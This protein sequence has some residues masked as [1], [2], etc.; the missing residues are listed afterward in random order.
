MSTDWGL[1]AQAHMA[2]QVTDA[3]QIQAALSVL[4]DKTIDPD[5]LTGS[6][7][8]FREAAIPYLSKG[9]YTAQT[10]AQTYFG[11][12]KKLAGLDKPKILPLAAL[13]APQ[14]KSSLTAATMKS[15]SLAYGVKQKGG[16]PKQ[17]LDAAK[18]NMLGSAKRQVLNTSRKTLVTLAETDKQITGWARVSDGR[19]CAFCAMLVSRGPVYSVGTVGFRAHDRCGCS[20]RPVPYN[21]PDKGWSPEALA[22]R[23]LW[24]QGGSKDWKAA[25]LGA[26]GSGAMTDLIAQA[27]T[28]LPTAVA[29]KKATDAAAEAVAAAAAKA[30]AEAAALKLAQEKAAQARAALA[31]KKAAEEA[32]E[33]AAKLAAE[34][35]AKLAKKKAAVEKMLATKAANKAAKIA[36]EKAAQEAAEKAAKKAAAVAKMVATKAAN[37]AA[38]QAAEAAA[39]AADKVA[40]DVA[41]IPATPADKVKAYLGKPAPKKPVAPIAPEPFGKAAFDEWTQKVK[42]RF[43]AYA[44]ATGNAKNDLT[45]SLNWPTVLRVIEQN[46]LSALD[47]L[48]AMS[49]VD[50]ALYAEAKAAMVKA[51]AVDPDAAKAFAEATLAHQRAD[52]VYKTALLD[53]RE[54]NGITSAPKGMDAGLR[55]AND[56]DGVSWAKAKLNV[57]RAGTKGYDAAKTYTGGSYSAWNAALRKNANRD[58]LPS[59]TYKTQTADFD[60]IFK[61]VPEDVIVRRGT[62]FSEFELG[63]VRKSGW[64]PPSPEDLVGTVQTQHG[65][66][67]TSVGATAAFGGE[68]KMR[69]LV[70]EG[71][72]AA[73][74]APFS[75]YG[76]A[77]RE[78]VLPRSSDFFIHEVYRESP[79]GAWVIEAELVPPGEDASTWTPMPRTSPRAHY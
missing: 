8:K 60:S 14:A 24:D 17:Y 31:A 61:P 16:N 42:D 27:L 58:T 46:D 48:K 41:K 7:L 52:G 44:K 23:M 6:F 4:W 36:A 73:L 26:S 72:P 74:V 37:K 29:A 3:A 25:Y 55:H 18:S 34:E 63:G 51:K 56:S 28:K 40:D 1:L 66:T 9:G 57:A 5:D 39:K 11:S 77:E 65:Y 33:A 70:P 67:S 54:V 59:G 30:A 20:V 43:A 75:R 32:A 15:L 12:V 78:F 22:Y 2:Q 35:A 64:P 62:S 50:D 76:W 53:W 21:D 10:T 49:Y 68:V 71:A 19:P 79:H 69:I 13:N 47:Q 38:K 45:K